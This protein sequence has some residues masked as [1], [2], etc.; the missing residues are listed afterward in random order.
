ARVR[1]MVAGGLLAEVAGLA[2][3]GAVLDA[4]GYRE[5]RAYIE[6]RTDVDAAIAATVRATR[7]FAKRQRTWFRREPGIVWYHPERDREAI[8]DAVDHFLSAGDVSLAAPA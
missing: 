4:V 1:A 2:Q 3:R 8:A 5:M 7:Q 6:G